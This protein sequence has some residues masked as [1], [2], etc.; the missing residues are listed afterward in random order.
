[1]NRRNVIKSLAILPV[2]M[3][4]PGALSAAVPLPSI[5]AK[6]KS[7]YEA[8]GVK[9]ILNAR[10]TVTVIGAS[11]VLPEV[12]DA[13]DAAI[14]EFVQID[15]LMDGVG[16][17]LAELMGTE[18]GC[19]TA[20][21][22]AAITAATAGC[23]TGGDP[24]KIWM[25]PNITGMKD[26]VV[27]T[28]YSRSAYDAGCK[29]V[30]V[31]MI[32][33]AN[34]I[35]LQAALGPRT[36]MVY[37]LAGEESER[38]ALSL[39]VISEITK[40][41]GIPILVD[42][43]AEG[44]EKPNPHISQGADLV[45]YSGGKYLR[46]PQCAGLLIGRKD[47]I[48]AA[49]MNTG[50]HH[51]FGRGFKVGREEVIGMLTAA[52]MWF[53]RDHE[54]EKKLWNTRLE[55]IANRIKSVPGLTTLI[56]QPVGRSNPSPDL[57]ISWDNTRIPYIGQEVEDLLWNGNPRISVG[58]AGSYFQPNQKTSILVNSSQMSEGDEKIV[59]NLIFEILSKPQPAAA[60]VA[61]ATTD[62]SGQ[63]DVET[64]FYASTVSQTFMIEQKGDAFEGTYTG[65]IGPRDLT[66]TIHGT[67]VLIRST[68]GVDGARVHSFFAG[69]VTGD[70]M[71]GELSLGEYGKATWK[72]WRHVYKMK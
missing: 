10:G 42:A 68:Y 58:S 57:I 44:P 40:P 45:A 7:V 51:G 4:V 63:W 34:V 11:K 22:S 5:A 67:D 38:G 56:K 60:T 62:L 43:A 49:R 3:A 17:R 54:A 41:L 1:M 9:P 70:T 30:G 28:S 33:V 66:G 55:S 25:I 61:A 18:S 12:R 8:I 39:K 47:L 19:V 16:R 26:E 72:A 14:H 6:R 69:K 46:G 31:R 13:M 37:L 36:A 21:A 15:E 23:V 59:A 64:K 2:S 53:K 29:A 50:P 32:Q 27:I 20:G 24:D 52:E 35:E 71:E 48:M 65:S